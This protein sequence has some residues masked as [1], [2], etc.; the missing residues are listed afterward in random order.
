MEFEGRGSQP[1][2]FWCYAD[3]DSCKMPRSY[4][5]SQRY[6][7]PHH[8]GSPA[9]VTVDVSVVQLAISITVHYGVHCVVS[10]YLIT[11]CRYSKY[12][13]SL[14]RSALS[15]SFH[16]TSLLLST[17]AGKTGAPSLRSSVTVYENWRVFWH[18][19]HKDFSFFRL[20]FFFLFSPNLAPTLVFDLGREKRCVRTSACEPRWAHR[21]HVSALCQ[22][23]HTA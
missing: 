3:F 6:P 21:F 12:R 10:E 16:N 19:A 7:Q 20:F 8:R 18:L 15:W 2:S 5:W 23:H 22:G 1:R 11:Y 4:R 17:S 14:N 9:E 13:S